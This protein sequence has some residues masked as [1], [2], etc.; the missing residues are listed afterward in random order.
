[1][2]MKRFMALL[3]ALTITAAVGC[4]TKIE[5]N[6]SIAAFSQNSESVAET[7][8]NVDSQSESE[9]DASQIPVF[10]ETTISAK[11]VEYKEYSQTYNAESGEIKGDAKVKDTRK[12]FKGEGY[13]TN[14]KSESDWNHSFKLTD[15]QYYNVSVTIAADEKLKNGIAVNGNAVGEFTYDGNGKWQT[16]TVNNVFIEAGE[17]KLS[18]ASANDKID[19]DYCNIQSSDQIQ[20]LSQKLEKPKLIN[21]N[22]DY[23]AQALYSYLTQNYSK[24]IVLGQYDTVGTSAETQLVYKTTGKYPAIRFGDMTMF[25]QKNSVIAENEIP[26]AESWAEN[27]GIVGYMWHWTDPVGKTEYYADKTDFDLSKAV[28]KEKIATMSIEQIKKLQESG[29]ISKECVAVVEDIDA[30]SEKLAALRD[31]GI[32]VL[33][34][35]LHEASNGYF[36]WGKDAE[37]YKWLWQLLYERQT[38]YHKL[39]NLIWVWSAQNANWYVGDDYCDILSVDIYDNGSKASQVNSLLFL[40]SISKNKPI[41]MSECGNFPSIQNLANDK[42]MWSYI[43]QWG[44]NFLMNDDGTLS[45]QNNTATDLIT[46]Y[47]NNLTVTRDKLP[48]FKSLAANIKAESEKAAEEKED[49]ADSSQKTETQ[50]PDETSAKKEETKKSE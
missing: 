33:W 25:T 37:S 5:K 13:V 10:E 24:K 14:I 45:E 6:D 38:E 20:N 39:N 15:S 3:I 31:D 34:R 35:P 1:M 47:N 41:A 50:K 9:I 27:G 2:K 21:K 26:T 12:D 18:L 36:W 23:N 42:T 19:I 49:S 11:K 43:G 46:M 4:G 32:A 17:V 16:F 28:T 22:A 8:N 7:V 40:Q 44:G 30:V 29:K 48:D